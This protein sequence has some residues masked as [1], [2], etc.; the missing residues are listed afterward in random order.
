MEERMSKASGLP[1]HSIDLDSPESKVVLAES[2]S[3]LSRR[4]LLIQEVAQ[5]KYLMMLI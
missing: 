3:S 2:M 4:Q 1:Y 5:G